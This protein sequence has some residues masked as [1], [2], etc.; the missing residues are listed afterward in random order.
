MIELYLI[1]HLL[2]GLGFAVWS[3]FLTGDSCAGKLGVFVIALLSGPW[4]L[5]VAK[6]INNDSET[7]YKE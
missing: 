2:C 7:V 6:T 1:F 3:L 4:F 5:F